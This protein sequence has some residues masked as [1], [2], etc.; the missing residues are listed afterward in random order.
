MN[1]PKLIEEKDRD[2][3]YKRMGERTPKNPDD[4]PFVGLMEWVDLMVEYKN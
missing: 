3:W 4:Y 1:E 2:S